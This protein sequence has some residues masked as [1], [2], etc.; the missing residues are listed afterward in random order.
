MFEI[1]VRNMPG[2]P[3]FRDI[4]NGR[5]AALRTL[6]DQA[7]RDLPKVASEVLSDGTAGVTTYHTVLASGEHQ[8]VVQVTR[9]LLGGVLSAVQVAGFV[10]SSDGTRRDLREDETWEFT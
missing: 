1:G 3:N 9:D 5:A 2:K 6:D 4:A 7:I 8:V 10:L